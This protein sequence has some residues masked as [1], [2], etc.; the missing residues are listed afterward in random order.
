MSD[1]PGYVFSEWTSRTIDS[2]YTVAY[3]LDKLVTDHCAAYVNTTQLRCCVTGPLLKQYIQDTSFLGLNGLIRFDEAGNLLGNYL[4][5]QIVATNNSYEQIT[6]GYWE[7]SSHQVNTPN[8]LFLSPLF[9]I[10]PGK[11]CNVKRRW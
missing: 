8:V 10:Y 1:D 6:L 11:E 9:S 5:K 2:I 4:I 3:A 7:S